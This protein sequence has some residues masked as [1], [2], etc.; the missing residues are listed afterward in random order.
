VRRWLPALLGALL[1]LAGCG[2]PDGSEDPASQPEASATATATAEVDETRSPG[3]SAL[4]DVEAPG[5]PY[6]AEELLAL[7]RDSRRP[8]GVPDEIE[9][10]EVAAALAELIWTLGGRP[11][12]VASVGGECGPDSC[13]LEVA[14]APS[15]ASGEDLYLFRVD[16]ATGAVELVQSVL[17]GMDAETVRELDRLVR[18]RY[19]GDL[20][21]FGLATARWLPPP[22]DGRFVL[23]YRSGG[24]EGSP[25]IDLV[26]DVRT[27]EVS[28]MPASWIRSATG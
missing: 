8:G 15:E 1:V 22:D 10:P 16:P 28:E 12:A 20:D 9:T 6:D 24:E 7:M 14:G 3:P 21:D 2:G 5:R 26:F 11:W 23:A 4:V 13:N 18:E 17:L 25:A 19:D 27:G